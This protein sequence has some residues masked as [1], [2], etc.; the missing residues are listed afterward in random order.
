MNYLTTE[1]RKQISLETLLFFTNYCTANG[2]RYWLAY[3]TLLG[4]VRHSGFIP[5]DDD[6]DVFMPRPDYERFLATFLDVSGKYRAVTCFTRR[7]YL[8][9]FAKIQD[10]ST[11]KIIYDGTADEFHGYGLD[12]FPID[13]M[14]SNKARAERI[15]WRKNWQFR[16]MAFRVA[17]FR[18]VKKSGFTGTLK[19]SIGTAAYKTGFTNYMMRKL[20]RSPYKESFE[21]SGNIGAFIGV[22]TGKFTCFKKEWFKTEQ[23]PFEGHLMNVPA[24]RHEILTQLYGDY[25]TPPPEEARKSTHTEEFVF[26]NNLTEETET[27]KATEE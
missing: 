6:V 2:L 18:L 8:L 14:P 21:E 5:W 19:R 20:S 27:G 23:I 15:F 17:C 24:G 26:R 16:K 13:G 3:G 12:I 11:A 4:A 25:M 22:F 7:D 9:P 10:S 1:E